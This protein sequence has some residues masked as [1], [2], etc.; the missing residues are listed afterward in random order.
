MFEL[1]VIRLG[2]AEDSQLLTKLV[3]YTGQYENCVMY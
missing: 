2:Y 1:L 3:W